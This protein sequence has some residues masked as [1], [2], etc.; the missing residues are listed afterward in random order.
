VQVV[1]EILVDAER[2]IGVAGFRAA[3]RGQ[4]L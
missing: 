1:E 3:L 2:D 4:V